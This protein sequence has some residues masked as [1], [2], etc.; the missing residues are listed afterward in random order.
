MKTYR[1]VHLQVQGR[2]PPL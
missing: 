1:T 2:P